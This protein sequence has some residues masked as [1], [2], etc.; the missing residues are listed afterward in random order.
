VL[1]IRLHNDLAGIKKDTEIPPCPSRIFMLFAKH[2]LVGA[3]LDGTTGDVTG[4]VGTGEGAAGTLR[5]PLSDNDL[6]IFMA[7]ALVI[8]ELG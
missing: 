6:K 2:Q 8:G 1:F 4:L 5:Y 7:S 3:G